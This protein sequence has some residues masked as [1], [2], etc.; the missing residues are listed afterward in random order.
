MSSLHVH[1]CL[2]GLSEINPCCDLHCAAAHA[3]AVSKAHARAHAADA[4]L[5]K[6]G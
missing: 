1:A 3:L 4:V 2:I 6:G 5:V